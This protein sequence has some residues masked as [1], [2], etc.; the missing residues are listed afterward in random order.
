MAGQ[1]L[2]SFVAIDFETA[3]YQFNSACAVGLV[4]VEKGLIR[5]CHYYLIRPPR[6]RFCFT[7]IHGLTWEDVADQPTFGELWPRLLPLL[8][9]AEF[10]AA[11]NAGFDRAV[12]RSCCETYGLLPP[13][14]PFRCTMELARRVWRIYPT[15]LPDVCQQL[16][17]A[18]NHHH[19]ASDA[20]AC[21][22]I[23]LAALK[24]G[25]WK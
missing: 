9:G 20:E 7:H 19:A 10:L 21:A 5:D 13:P 25:K 6:P 17:I 12:L 22:R 4:R 3:E 8:E 2:P 15:K 11:H 18:L 14:L 23:V 24:A 16:G 1:P